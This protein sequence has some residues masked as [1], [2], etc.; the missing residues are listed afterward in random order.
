M[1]SKNARDN[2]NEFKSTTRA[3]K[4]I[5]PKKT[6]VEKAKEGIIGDYLA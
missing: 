5:K 1:Q 2:K 6:L 3:K 4:A